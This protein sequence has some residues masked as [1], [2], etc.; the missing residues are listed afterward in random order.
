M[1]GT[2]WETK[3]LIFNPFWIFQYGTR[4]ILHSFGRQIAGKIGL[5][6][7]GKFLIPV[8]MK[9][10]REDTEFFLIT[11]NVYSYEFCGYIFVVK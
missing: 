2:R 11:Q 5:Q 8:V 9:V 7:H 6:N 3:D 10:S 4:E 1:K